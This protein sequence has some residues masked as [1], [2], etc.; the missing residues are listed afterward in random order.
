MISCPCRTALRRPLPLYRTT[1]GVQDDGGR[2]ACLLGV[3]VVH[4][5]GKP[6][7]ERRPP[8]VD[9]RLGQDEE[10]PVERRLAV[11]PNALVAQQAQA[12]V[13]ELVEADVIGTVG[14]PN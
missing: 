9:H 11:E 12:S 13:A 6:S 7:L 5:A 10:L 14:S 4:R 3:E 2:V 8:A 1:K